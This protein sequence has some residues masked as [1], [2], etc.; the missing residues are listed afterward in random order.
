MFMS[1]VAPV[2]GVAVYPELAGARVLITGLSSTAGVDTG[3]AFAD[4][5]TRLVLA[6]TDTSPAMTELVSHLAQEASEIRLFQDP[7]GAD[8][9]RLTQNAVQAFSGLDAVVNFV[10]L[11]V[12]DL[13]DRETKREIEDYVAAKLAPVLDVTRVAA[14][15][16]SLT[17]TEGSILNVVLMPQPATAR[18]AALSGFARTALAAMTKGEAKAAAERAVRINA[19]GPRSTAASEAAGACLSSGPEIASLALHLASRKGRQLSGHMFD[20]EEIALRAC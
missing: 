10:T 15:R 19:I 20:A 4:H 17:W 3:R 16:M 2:P 7:M 6:T 12:A 5:K 13:E 8:P 11:S 18:E 1:V 9:I 14:N